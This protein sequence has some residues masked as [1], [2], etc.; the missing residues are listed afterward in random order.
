MNDI[1]IGAP[2]KI[3][4]GLMSNGALL[5][6]PYLVFSGTVD[7]PTVVTGP[8]SS[9]ITLNL[10]NRLINL[11]RPNQRRYTAADQHLFYPDDRA[12]NWVELLN[13]ISLKEGTA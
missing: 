13:D 8:T 3:Y 2:A 11:Q 12:F 1:S 4:F 5:G 7:K 9:S 6:A 10:E